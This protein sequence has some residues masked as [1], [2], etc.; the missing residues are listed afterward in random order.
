MVVL[1]VYLSL[2]PADI[3]EDLPS[4]DKTAHFVAYGA[5]MI[6]FSQLYLHRSRLAFA[7]GF[8]VMGLALEL[9]QGA[10]G[11]RSFELL[12]I[13]ANTAGV[14]LGWVL[15]VSLFAGWLRRAEHWLRQR[16]A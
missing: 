6:W 14:T 15:G 3:A 16:M 13:L 10:L 5:L 9:L 1:I 4:S 12:D 2:A 7:M 11:H 8:I